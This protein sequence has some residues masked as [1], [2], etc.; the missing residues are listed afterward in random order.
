MRNYLSV[1]VAMV[2]LG[3]SLATTVQAQNV[4]WQTQRKMLKSQQKL[5]WHSLMV[6]QQNRKLS[7]KGQRVAS[8]QRTEANHQMERERR[9]LKQRQ[10][11]AK[12]DMNDRQRSLKAMQHAFSG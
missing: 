12:Q 9:D 2:F 3:I 6:Q 5:E 10:K 4:D 7:W 11:D 8:T 1:M